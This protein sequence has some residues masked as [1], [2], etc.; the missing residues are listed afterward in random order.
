MDAKVALKLFKMDLQKYNKLYLFF[1]TLY[2]LEVNILLDFVTICIDSLTVR[3]SATP[4][5]DLRL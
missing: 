5:P 3:Q 1:F 4:A 2:N